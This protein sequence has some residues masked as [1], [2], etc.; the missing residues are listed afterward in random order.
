MSPCELREWPWLIQ[1]RKR[2]VDGG[3]SARLESVCERLM[4]GWKSK[5]NLEFELRAEF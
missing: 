2:V 4:K 3:E 1:R 5:R